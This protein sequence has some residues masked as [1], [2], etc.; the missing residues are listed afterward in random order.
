M[1]GLVEQFAVLDRTVTFRGQGMVFNE[2]VAVGRVPRL[3]LVRDRGEI[4]LILC[5]HRWES[6]AIGGGGAWA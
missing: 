6:I 2:G 3:A 4:L 5:N 1:G